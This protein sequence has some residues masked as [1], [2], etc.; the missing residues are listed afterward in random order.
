MSTTPAC[1]SGVKSDLAYST[2]EENGGEQEELRPLQHDDAIGEEVS[3][4]E[5]Q[6]VCESII[7]Q[8]ISLP[9]SSK[10]SHE[11]V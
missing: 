5:A 1:T 8:V 6:M 11:C 9:H 3:F 4:D 7:R 2:A 10:F